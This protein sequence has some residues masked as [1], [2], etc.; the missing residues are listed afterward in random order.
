MKKNKKNC[1]TLFAVN[2]DHQRSVRISISYS[3]LTKNKPHRIYET[4]YLRV[5]DMVLS[6]QKNQ[7]ESLHR[8]LRVILMVVANYPL[9]LQQNL[10]VRSSFTLT[11]WVKRFSNFIN[12]KYMEVPLNTLIHDAS[13]SMIS[14]RSYLL[15][16]HLRLNTFRDVETTIYS[17]HTSVLK[18]I[19]YIMNSPIAGIYTNQLK[20]QEKLSHNSTKF[21]SIYLCVHPLR[22][23]QY[24]PSWNSLTLQNIE[25]ICKPKK[26]I[27]K[28]RKGC[29]TKST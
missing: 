8:T 23:V 25:D 29:S 28:K 4:I 5:G 20:S 9:F 3:G 1:V 11:S 16:G 7:E 13:I 10:S 14:L 27:K 22:G 6:I 12:K 24:L 19:H 26:N 21:P 17:L 2:L 18:H 15:G